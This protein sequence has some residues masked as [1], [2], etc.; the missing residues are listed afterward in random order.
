[1]VNKMTAT[2]VLIAIT[3]VLAMLFFSS[4]DKSAGT[5]GGSAKDKIKVGYIVNGNRL[6]IV[7][8]TGN[9]TVPVPPGMMTI[10]SADKIS[11]IG[12]NIF[13]R[14]NYKNQ[15][16][17]GMSI[18]NNIDQGINL[19]MFYDNYPIVDA[20]LGSGSNTLVRTNLSSFENGTCNGCTASSSITFS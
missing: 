9:N 3:A 18:T 14:G 17:A 16:Q 1:M 7:D 4:A 6:T 19:K 20:V 5:L 2:I 15:I 11:P 8:I 12:A 13:W 10:Y